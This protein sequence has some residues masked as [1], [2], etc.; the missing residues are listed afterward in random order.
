MAFGPMQM[1]VVSY[2]GTELSPEV[3]AELKRLREHDI[4]RLVDLLVV[5]KDEDGNV[6]AIEKSDL[7]K[8]ESTELGALAGALIGLGAA[9]EDGMELGALAGAEAAES[10]GSLLEGEA[11]YVADAIPPGSRAAVAIIEHRWAIPLRDALLQAGAVGLV[12]AWIHPTD[13]IA[14]G[15][16][17]GLEIEAGSAA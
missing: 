11:W 9:G 2:E 13:L 6:T 10:G 15:R 3:A 12:D 7:T 8:D 5:M 1:L 17:I 16:Q 4:V 14:A